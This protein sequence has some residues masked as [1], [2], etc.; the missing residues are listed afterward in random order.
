M[1]ISITVTASRFQ[2]SIGFEIIEFLCF[3]WKF[4]FK[5][6]S[7]E[8]Q[9]MSRTYFRLPFVKQEHQLL[10]VLLPRNFRY[11]FYCFIKLFKR[12]RVFRYIDE[13]YPSTRSGR[14]F[15]LKL[16]KTGFH[17]RNSSAH[18]LGL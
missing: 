9:K 14:I 4:L 3:E 8:T 15:R 1:F 7:F 17:V 2:C 11:L 5:D 10:K 6:T 18:V 12:L 16:A 13:Q